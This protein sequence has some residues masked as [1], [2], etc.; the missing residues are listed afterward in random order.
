M[1]DESEMDEI[2]PLTRAGKK[3]HKHTR[4]PARETTPRSNGNVAA[5]TRDAFRATAKPIERV[6]RKRRC[7]RTRFIKKT[8]QTQE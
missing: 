6:R 4:A 5:P 1:A 2:N 7:G 8:T 3:T